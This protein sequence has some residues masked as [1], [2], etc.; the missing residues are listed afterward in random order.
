MPSQ[1]G[2]LPDLV[3]LAKNPDTFETAGNLA[4]EPLELA[5]RLA[6]LAEVLEAR[7][8]LSTD[9]TE[10]VDALRKLARLR[11]ER[12]D[13][14]AGALSAS[15]ALLDVVD[16]D[17]PLS[18]ALDQGGRLAVQ[19]GQGGEHV[20]LLAT[21]AENED[22]PPEARI[23][24]ALY[25]ANLAEEVLGDPQRALSLLTPLIAAGLATLEVCL[26]AERLGRA[27]HDPDAVAAALVEGARLAPEPSQQSELLVR[28]GNARRD[29]GEASGALEA[30]REAFDID[31]ASSAVRGMEAL[32]EGRDGAPTL[33]LLDALENATSL[34]VTAGDRP[35][36]PRCGSRRPTTRITP[37]CWSSWRCCARRAAA[38]PKRRSMLGGA[39][40]ST[41]PTRRWS[42]IGSWR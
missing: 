38:P 23:A 32:L 2:A 4:M 21:R 25:A 27:A 42:S 30:Y 3:R 29:V 28:L 18:E 9:P 16:G 22:L 14:L 31:R 26:R 39:C 41:T 1:D 15:N 17:E 24:T 36:S 40:S 20:D 19:L 34:R 37:G 6:E 13:D 33:A 7:A 10:K 8:N 5:G 35:M 11:V 12:L